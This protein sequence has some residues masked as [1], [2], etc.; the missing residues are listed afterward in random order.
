MSNL[1]KFFLGLIAVYIVVM[2]VGINYLRS[3]NDLRA[4][5]SLLTQG[6]KK[7]QKSNVNLQ[8]LKEELA[9][10]KKQVK[11]L[12][13]ENKKLKKD[14]QELEEIR[15]ILVDYLE[16]GSDDDEPEPA[17][18]PKFKYISRTAKFFN[19]TSPFGLLGAYPDVSHVFQTKPKYHVPHLGIINEDDYCDRA[20]L[21]NLAHPEV[22]LEK[23][24]FFSDYPPLTLPRKE[25]MVPT[26][27]MVMPQV[28]VGIPVEVFES[29]KWRLKPQINNFFNNM[30]GAMDYYHEIGKN[31]ACATQMYNHIPGHGNL[32]QKDSLLDSFRPYVEKYKNKPQCFNETSYFLPFFRLYDK[33]ECTDFFEMVHSEKYIKS[34]E[35]E[36]IQ[37]LVKI[38]RG[39]HK[40]QGVFLLN[41]E[42][43]AELD[44]DY[45]KG[46][47]CGELK[48]SLIVQGYVSN[49]L[50][51]D[52][53]NK[54]D[55]RLY[56][57]IASTN[58]LIM[59]YHDGFLRVAL[60]PFDTKSSDKATH[61]T[62]TYLANQKIED[63]KKA[64][65]LINGM[66]EKELLEYH[67][68]SFDKLE[69]YLLESGKVTD[70][71]W[72][73]NYLRPAIH[74]AI[75]HVLKMTSHSFLKHSNLYELHGLDFILDNDMKLWFIESNPSPLLTG[76]TKHMIYHETIRDAMDIMYAYYR[77]RMARFV[78]L[79]KNMEQDPK[80]LTT[81]L[82]KWKAEF[83]LAA[84]NRLEPEHQVS[85][86]NTYTLI[87]DEGLEGEKKYMGLIEKECVLDN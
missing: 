22:L 65:K 61:L 6:A 81:N 72:L 28:H 27:T 21:F 84:K 10:L 13:T 36:P 74:K 44:R 34:L 31:F 50:L 68:W 20:D 80:A 18:K 8:E 32:I 11:T 60:N 33:K 47:K 17:P 87:M 7:G 63:A 85:K 19:N 29:R 75:V 23:R 35:K 49:P 86:N 53:N 67:L 37:Y 14:N 9:K 38:A 39:S 66:T 82:P 54:F 70:P 15:K 48:K 41:D 76:T 4:N 12:Q 73:N 77:S 59:Y 26:G 25:I 58:P 78:K 16:N 64:D 62:N 79:I 69:K 43:V 24:N 5:T 30:R 71:N 51:L 57:L 1:L 56:G 55:F 40:G 45:S 42:Q 83:E 46:K 52:L 3:E 2:A